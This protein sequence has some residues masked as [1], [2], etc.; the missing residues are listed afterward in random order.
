MTKK[1]SGRYIDKSQ[2]KTQERQRQ[3]VLNKHLHLGIGVYVMILAYLI[4]IVISFTLKTETSF[5]VA[6]PG[7]IVESETFRGLIIR[8]EVVVNSETSGD[9]HFFITEGEKV[10]K[11]TLVSV[12]DNGG[13]VVA[14]IANQLTTTFMSSDHDAQISDSIMKNISDQV[15][16]FVLQRSFSDYE[17][18]Y[19]LEHNM[20]KSVTDM[21]DAGSVYQRHL[22]KNDLDYSNL[23][24]TAYVTDDNLYYSPNS[25]V[26]SFEIDGFED[27]NI[28]SFS[29]DRIDLLMQ[30]PEA[31]TYDSVE[32]GQPLYKV[33]D[34]YKWYIATEI[35]DVCEKFLEGKTNVQIH[36]AQTSKTLNPSIY[37]GKVINADDKTYLLLEMDRYLT[38]YMNVRFIDF[39]IVYNNIE[40]LKIPLSAVAT[41]EFVEIPLEALVSNH[42]RQEVRK[43]IS[44][45]SAVGK[46]TLESIAIGMYYNNDKKTY[47][48]ITEL[49]NVGD[50][51]VYALSNGVNQEFIIGESFPVEGVYV[52]NKGFASFKLIETLTYN[53]DYRII[54]DSTPYGVCIYDR[55]AS[56]A[57]VV[58]ENE[59]VE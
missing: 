4:F 46:E 44:N 37:S 30:E 41:K 19:A 45:E 25:G 57:S 54:S 38:D 16:N 5:S 18:V 22:T 31:S 52:I 26:I 43:K 58:S 27:L 35:N 42:N 55:I 29:T 34:N 56:D 21:S 1:T 20:A 24:N 10:K 17:N 2:E 40:G 33:V 36:I 6:E 49:L 12:V 48:P 59:V 51:I 13:D 11:G 8:K 15:K 14:A 7:N 9:T 53:D 28:D 3:N 32:N 47:I 23:S 39:T 50:T